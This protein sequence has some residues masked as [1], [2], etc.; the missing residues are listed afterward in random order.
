[1]TLSRIP[2]FKLVTILTLLACCLACEDGMYTTS[3]GRCVQCDISCNTCRSSDGC[4]TCYDQMYL[5]ARGNTI[6]C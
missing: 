1:M 4:S 5:M 6:I 3:T 2:T